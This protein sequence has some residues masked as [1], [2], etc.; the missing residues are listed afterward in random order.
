MT[1]NITYFKALEKNYAISGPMTKF[2]EKEKMIQESHIKRFLLTIL[3]LKFSQNIIGV[4]K[5]QKT[6]I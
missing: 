3:E 5:F 1:S 2:K 4:S 6:D